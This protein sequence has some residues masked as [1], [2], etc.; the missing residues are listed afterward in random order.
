MAANPGEPNGVPMRDSRPSSSMSDITLGGLGEEGM[1]S[2]FRVHMESILK[3]FAENVEELYKTVFNLSSNM[4]EVLAKAE[5]NAGILQQHAERMDAAQK[6]QN[7]L[8]EHAEMTRQILMETKDESGKAEQA[9]SLRIEKLD[10][11]LGM[12]QRAIAELKKS[13]EDARTKIGALQDAG[14]QTNLNLN[15]VKSELNDTMLNL[16]RTDKEHAAT[17]ETMKSHKNV[18]DAHIKDTEELTRKQTVNGSLFDNLNQHCE[19]RF[20]TLDDINAKVQRQLVQYRHESQSHT[21]G[22]TQL[23]SE[24]IDQQNVK[25]QETLAKLGQI[26]GQHAKQLAR[27]DE[28]SLRTDQILRI[29][30]QRH[31]DHVQDMHRHLGELG[32]FAS[33][34]TQ[35]IRELQTA[36]GV[37]PGFAQSRIDVLEEEAALSYKQNGRLEKVLKLQPMTKENADELSNPHVTLQHGVL[38]TD[39]QINEFRQAFEKYDVDHSGNVNAQEVAGIL[40]SLGLEVNQMVIDLVMK[41]FDLDGSGEVS[42]DEF[43]DLMTKM[44]GPDG[45]FDADRYMK[46]ISEVALREAKQNE[47]VEL[48]PTVQQ[49]V[50]KH[51]IVIEAEQ[52][53]LHSATDRLQSLE[54]QHTDLLKEVQ[55]LRKELDLNTASWKGITRG[56]KETKKTVHTEGDG[57]AAMLQG[58]MRLRNALPPL[59]AQKASTKYQFA[60]PREFESM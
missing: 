54:G 42:F 51:Q 48:F 35:E 10:E 55:K 41:E 60:T 21:D 50:Q 57:D 5:S 17:I 16:D 40:S 8:M 47:I 13:S 34:H 1:M 59:A 22:S 52:S 33:L 26:E 7:D 43:C 24:R 3:P 56:F 15:H 6:R 45:K 20:K 28:N 12:M 31:L 53:K 49:D 29:Q 9:R 32:K 25:I 30:D 23:T 36:T 11:T 18:L 2:F 39:D 14:K 58:A 46:S 38:L 4:Q 37:F 19:E 44:L 27:L